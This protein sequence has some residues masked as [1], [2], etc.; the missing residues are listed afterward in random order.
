MEQLFP[1]SHRNEFTHLPN[2]RRIRAYLEMRRK[3]NKK[4]KLAA[5]ASISLF[6]SES[7]SIFIEFS[8]TNWNQFTLVRS[9]RL[10]SGSTYA[11]RQQSFHYS[12]VSNRSRRMRTPHIRY[13]RS[14]KLCLLLL[15]PSTRHVLVMFIEASV[16]VIRARFR[17]VTWYNRQPSASVIL[18]IGCKQ[19]LSHT[20]IQLG[21]QVCKTVRHSRLCRRQLVCTVF[22]C[23]W[24]KK[25][26][27]CKFVERS[28]EYLTC[29][30]RICSPSEIKRA[31]IGI[32]ST[33]LHAKQ[34]ICVLIVF[35]AMQSIV[36]QSKQDVELPTAIHFNL[37]LALWVLTFQCSI[38]SQQ[39]V[40][41]FNSSD[42]PVLWIDESR[43]ET[44]PM[45][46]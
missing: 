20:L 30:E 44:L 29:A 39:V 15:F 19:K 42:F 7:L 10:I 25:T 43:V 37:S 32:N 2:E 36:S 27:I 46:E 31:I 17:V 4:R 23:K 12:I 38:R 3:K 26:H 1:I 21:D 18:F 35:V 33:F 11:R 24:R 28:L 40:C 6:R 45:A 41:K 13:K 16:S 14:Y 8:S 34:C 9:A 5:S 22:E